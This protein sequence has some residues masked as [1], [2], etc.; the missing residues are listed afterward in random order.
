[1]DW[2]QVVLDGPGD[3][4]MPDLDPAVPELADE[5]GRD[6]LLEAR[7]EV[8][9]EN[10]V[11]AARTGDRARRETV[12]ER[13]ER[14][15]HGRRGPSGE[16]LGGRREE[17]QDASRLGAATGHPGEH[18]LAERAAQGHARQLP[19]PGEDLLGDERLP[20]GSLGN[21]Q[22]GRRRGPL[23]LDLGDELGELGPLE[24]SDVA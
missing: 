15:R 10:A 21:E 5:A 3:E 19:P 2:Q 11:A 9:V 22:E 4:L 16:W 17:A 20:T 13:R 12:G 6:R 24:R 8:R 18:E 7:P 14:R 1:L 23:A